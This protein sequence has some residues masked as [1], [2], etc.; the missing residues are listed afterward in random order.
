MKVARLS[1]L[2]TSRLYPQE[3]LLVLI[4]VAQWLRHFATNRNVAGSI[5]D[6]VIGIFHWHN[7]SGRSMALGS[8]RTW[9]Y[10][11]HW[12]IWPKKFNTIPPSFH[13]LLRSSP[14]EHV[15]GYP[16]TFPM[17]L[18]HPWKFSSMNVSLNSWNS[19][20]ISSFVSKWYP[21][22]RNFI[23]GNRKK[24]QGARSVCQNLTVGALISCSA[25]T[26]LVCALFKKLSLFGHALHLSRYRKLV[27]VWEWILFVW[28]QNFN[29]S[30]VV[31]LGQYHDLQYHLIL[32]C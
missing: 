23:L 12:G 20:W 14:L 8:T 32:P 28:G 29:A 15:Y 30:F 3:T 22:G 21:F 7:P 13:R 27:G 26:V 10:P 19:A 5:P 9:C 25:L 11:K 1:A 17:I 4:S 18:M 24:L 6:G 2:R 16:S 31:V